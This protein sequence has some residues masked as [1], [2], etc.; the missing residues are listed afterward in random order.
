MSGPGI[1][2]PKSTLDDF[3]KPRENHFPEGSWIV[4]LEGVRERSFP[5]FIA[6]NVAS[7]KNVGYLSGDGETLDLQFGGAK[8]T[9]GAG[10]TNQKLFVSLVTRDGDVGIDAGPDIPKEAWQLQNSAALVLLIA[11]ALGATEEVEYNGGTYVTASDDFLSQ[12]RGG[13]FD[14]SRVGVTTYHRKWTAKT[15]NPDGTAKTGV[16]VKV[17]EVF[18]AV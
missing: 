15:K 9:N 4:T 11:Q 14:G 1:M 6:T 10:E 18:Q 17:R 3:S 2:V 13:E 8:S 7:G 5:D 12:L 16:E